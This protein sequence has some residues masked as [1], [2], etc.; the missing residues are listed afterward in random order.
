MII[1]PKISELQQRSV[2]HQLYERTQEMAYLQEFRHRL[3]LKLSEAE[4]STLIFEYIALTLQNPK[5]ACISI[6][7]GNKKITSDNYV[8]R[9]KS[10]AFNAKICTNGHQYGQISVFYLEE[11]LCFLPEEQCFI[12]AIANDLGWWFERKNKNGEH[13]IS[14]PIHESKDAVKNISP[15]NCSDPL[16]NLPNKRQLID[17]LKL[18]SSVTT[19]T[20]LFGALLFIDIDN[21]KSI[22]DLAGYD[23]GDHILHEISNRIRHSLYT[24][25]I[26][27]RFGGDEFVIMLP[28]L[29]KDK[30]VASQKAIKIAERIRR[31]I[32]KAYIINKNEYFVSPSGGI[33]IF[34]KDDSLDNLLKQADAAM[35]QAKELGGNRIH[36][37]NPSMQKEQEERA[38]L[39]LE[40]R[41]ALQDKQLQLHYQIQINSDNHAIGVEALIR[42]HHPNHGFI[43]PQKF[44]SLAE[45]SCLSLD[46]G[47]WII[48]KACKQLSLWRKNPRTNQ[49]SIAIN[50]SSRQFHEKNFVERVSTAINTHGINPSLLKLELTE[51]IVMDHVHAIEKIKELRMLGVKLSLDDFGTGYSSLSYLKKLEVDQLK[52]DQSFVRDISIGSDNEIMVRTIISLANNF[53]LDVLA[54]GVET[55]YQLAFLKANNC[56]K[57]Q[58]YLFG[59]PLPIA[60]IDGLLNK[61]PSIA[62]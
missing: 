4:I 14:T 30:T 2:H 29:D 39:E 44:I 28:N 38:L 43:S 20:R 18:A 35:Y 11:K 52:I 31:S 36:F 1:E 12:N 55:E 17:R 6:K 56:T 47:Q 62:D 25:N 48:D 34:G 7:L 61:Y 16:T 5:L 45:E 37:F 42:W 9:K 60:D 19:D 24:P 15:L 41:H 32:N 8:Q 46:I 10:A 57:F 59:K 13:L 26:V 23:I 22:N 51:G 49:L 54:E 21:F 50:I 58:G 3:N 53:K 33:S 27:S 40:L